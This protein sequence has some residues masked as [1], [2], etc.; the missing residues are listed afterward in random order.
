M[1]QNTDD[2]HLLK[3]KPRLQRAALSQWILDMTVIGAAVSWFV[4]IGLTWMV[5]GQAPTGMDVFVGSAF[6]VM[7]GALW[8]NYRGRATYAQMSQSDDLRRQLEDVMSSMADLMILMSPDGVIQRVNKATRKTLGYSQDEMVGQSINHFWVQ[9]SAGFSALDALHENSSV[10]L[11]R[12]F[13][14]QAGRF[15]PMAVTYTAV[16]AHDGSLQGVLCVAQDLS[17]VESIRAQLQATNQRYNA[18]ISSSRLGVYEYDPDTNQLVVDSTLKLMLGGQSKDIKSLDDALIYVPIEDHAKVYTALNHVLNGKIDRIEIEIRLGSFEHGLRWLQVRGALNPNDGRLFGTLM[19]VTA[20]KATEDALENRD[21]I[22]RAVADASGMFLH[23]PDWENHLPDMLKKLGVA[24][25]VSR[26]YVFRKHIAPDDRTLLS[27]VAEWCDLETPPQIDN[28]ELQNIDLIGIGF[29]R[30]AQVLSANDPLY[31]ALDNFPQV[32][33]DFL[34]NQGIKSLLIAPIF[35]DDEWWGM[36]GFDDC[37]LPRVWDPS[38]IDALKLAADILGAAIFRAEADKILEVNRQF[39]LSI[40]DNL[41]QGVTV[42]NDHRKFIY[43]NPAYAQ[44][45]GLT[46]DELIGRMPSEFTEEEDFATLEHNRALRARGMVS[47][48]NSHLRHQ[49]DGH[50]TEV[51]ITGVPRLI[52]NKPAGAYCVVADVTE[53]RRLESQRFELLLEKERVRLMSDFVRDISHEFRTPLSIIQT[54]LYLL[55]RKPDH[56][57][58]SAR[59]DVIGGQATRLGRLIDDLMLMLELEQAE[60]VARTLSLNT[61]A[62]HVVKKISKKA[63]EKHLILTLEQPDGEVSVRGEE[64]YLGRAITMLIDNAMEFTPEGGN[65]TVIV[66]SE[67]EYAVISIKD[68]GVGIPPDEINNIFEHMYKVDKARNTER[69]GLGLGLSIVRRISALH[70]GDVL[71]ESEVGKGSTFTLRLPYPTQAKPK[72]SVATLT[73]EISAVV[74]RATDEIDRAAT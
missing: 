65:I 46:P 7:G 51:L 33:Q 24:V 40:M 23:E 10:G 8:L 4:L 53:R 58:A 44:M 68:T 35:A 49:Q 15:L 48:Y 69:G 18:A 60:I 61:M 17:E 64:A 66:R 14:T 71:V 70:D 3:L 20:R 54:S 36:I 57:Q 50:L 63:E 16:T 45:I 56:P 11:T 12:N 52:D 25:D 72:A 43:V 27:Q 2:S 31:G 47:N 74:I 21:A 22:M 42:V 38:M 1:P 13:R 30:W 26:V 39:T 67:P 28:P 19:D 55:K 6:L 5:E 29:E 73:Q 32:E 37:K 9:G 59:L 41:G 62:G 34:I